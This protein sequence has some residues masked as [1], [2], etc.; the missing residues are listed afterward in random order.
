MSGGDLKLANGSVGWLDPISSGNA[1]SQKGA[2]TYGGTIEIGKDAGG[3][4]ENVGY[5]PNRLQQGHPIDFA[6]EQNYLRHMSGFWGALSPME[7]PRS[8]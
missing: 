3:V 6:A 1:A 2:I 5:D 7:Q 8:W 4:Y